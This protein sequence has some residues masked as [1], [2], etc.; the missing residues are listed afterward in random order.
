MSL[1]RL[2]QLILVLGVV[3]LARL[4]GAAREHVGGAGVVAHL[5]ADG[6]NVDAD[7]RLLHGLAQGLRLHGRGAVGRRVAGAG[8][9]GLDAVLVVLGVVLAVGHQDGDLAQ[10]RRAV[11]SR[12]GARPQ[13][14]PVRRE[15]VP[16]PGG[17]HLA[18]GAALAA[19]PSILSIKAVLV[20]GE[21]QYLASGVQRA[22]GDLVLFVGCH[23]PADRQRVVARA[24]S[25]VLVAIAPGALDHAVCRAVVVVVC[26]VSARGHGL[27]DAQRPAPDC[28]TP[29][30]PPSP[31]DGPSP[32]RARSTPWT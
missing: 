20:A 21:R 4:R 24:R 3:V 2:L 23:I 12:F 19:K 30:P 31:T 27:L 28:P 25:R 11:G 6:I 13:R 16:G 8:R 18:S 32:R 5:E 9:A 1:K 26:R 14:L 29:S 7:F 10:V 22:F 15:R 17:A